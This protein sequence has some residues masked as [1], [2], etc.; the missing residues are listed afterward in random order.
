M[1]VKRCNAKNLSHIK[2]KHTHKTLLPDSLYISMLADADVSWHA[3]PLFHF[4]TSFTAG[5][6]TLSFLTLLNMDAH[7]SFMSE[8]Y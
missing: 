3:T 6:S 4:F 8:K 1:M 2:T 7:S 5:V